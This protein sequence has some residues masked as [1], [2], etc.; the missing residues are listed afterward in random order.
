MINVAQ[1]PKKGIGI[2]FWNARSISNKMDNFKITLKNSHHKVF[3]ITESWLKPN[4]D[5][6]ILAITGFNI[7]RN[8]RKVMNRNGF[9]KRGGGILLYANSDLDVRPLSDESLNFSDENIEMLTTQVILPFT[10][11]LYILTVYR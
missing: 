10:R 1:N 6:S 3:C 11:P 9:L 5:S 2:V 4:M 8:D 7:F